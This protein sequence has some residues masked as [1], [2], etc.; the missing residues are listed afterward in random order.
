MLIECVKMLKA[1]SEGIRVEMIS[2]YSLW[3]RG[4]SSRWWYGNK[5]KSE[6]ITPG[7][8]GLIHSD[9]RKFPVIYMNNIP[10]FPRCGKRWFLFINVFDPPFRQ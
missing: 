2:L 6:D 5:R 10:A 9:T 4:H 3:N 7:Q 8:L 1:A